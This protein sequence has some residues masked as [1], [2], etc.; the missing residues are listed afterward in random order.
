MIRPDHILHPLPAGK[1]TEEEA[2]SHLKATFRQACQGHPDIMEPYVIGSADIGEDEPEF[3]AF[4][5]A[6]L[7]ETT[8]KRFPSRF[9]K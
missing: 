9:R 5:R 7:R 2:V 3:V 6:A 8:P 1:W 4:M